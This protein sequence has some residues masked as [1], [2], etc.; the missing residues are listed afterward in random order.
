MA[1]TLGCLHALLKPVP[2]ILSDAITLRSEVTAQSKDH[3][4]LFTTQTS[5]G[6]LAMLGAMR[7]KISGA[8]IAHPP[9]R[10]LYCRSLRRTATV[11]RMTGGL[12]LAWEPS[13]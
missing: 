12:T 7:G 5:R 9:R 11:L 8:T 10:D 3:C 6:I 4:L 13:P 1:L 2:V